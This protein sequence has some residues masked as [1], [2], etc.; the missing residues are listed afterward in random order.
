MRPA[1]VIGGGQPTRSDERDHQIALRADAQMEGF[2]SGPSAAF[3]WSRDAPQRRMQQEADNE[4]FEIVNLGGDRARI[5]VKS[6]GLCLEDPGRGGTIRQNRCNR[7]LM[8]Q[9]FILT[10]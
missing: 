2:Q 8:N 4:V 7:S 6:S 9:V 1:A 3:D 5:R 10:Q